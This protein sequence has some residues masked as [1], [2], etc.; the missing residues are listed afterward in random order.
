MEQIF[1]GVFY[2]VL[3]ILMILIA[4]IPVFIY[5]KYGREP[6]ITY[7]GIYE[8]EPPT[9]ESPAFVNALY[10]GNVGSVDMNAFKATIL[11]LVNKKI[12]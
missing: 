5:F 7:Q 12:Y 6:K 8:H 1:F 2:N 11:N 9:K 4:I 3:A 10:K